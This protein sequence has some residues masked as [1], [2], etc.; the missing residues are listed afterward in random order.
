MFKE[1]SVELNN[2]IKGEISAPKV[3]ARREGVGIAARFVN[4]SYS[5]YKIIRTSLNRLLVVLTSATSRRLSTQIPNSRPPDMALIVSTL[6]MSRL[7]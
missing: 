1:D 2:D 6:S 3:D 4:R 7:L 5:C